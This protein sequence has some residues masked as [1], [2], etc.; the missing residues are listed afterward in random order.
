MQTARRNEH[1]RAARQTERQLPPRRGDG[2][3]GGAASGG[4]S[5]VGGATVT[6]PRSGLN[7]GDYP[8]GPNGMARDL[9]ARIAELEAAKALCRARAERKPIK[10]HLHTLKGMLTWCKSRA[11]YVSTLADVGLDV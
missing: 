11:G 5:A 10:Q 2:G 1:G 9:E 8:K 3:S 7:D 6:L 4:E